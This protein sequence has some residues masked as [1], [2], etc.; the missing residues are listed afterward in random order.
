MMGVDDCQV[1]GEGYARR[2]A[3]LGFQSRFAGW[4]YPR[5]VP[6]VV[7]AVR[8][9]CVP[10]FVSLPSTCLLPGQGGNLRVAERDS[11]VGCA[12]PFVSCSPVFVDRFHAQQEVTEKFLA[13]FVLTFRLASM[14]AEGDSNSTLSPT[15]AARYGITSVCTSPVR[16]V[17]GLSILLCHTP[18]F[19]LR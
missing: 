4:L 8:W 11:S 12:S 5:L 19:C 18:S 3:V 17:H 16:L 2:L 9:R 6:V 15:R 10:G 1:W 14:R 7:C 13:V